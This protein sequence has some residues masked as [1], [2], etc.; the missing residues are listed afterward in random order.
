MIT[1]VTSAMRGPMLLI[2]SGFQVR[3]ALEMVPTLA[4]VLDND[5]PQDIVGHTNGDVTE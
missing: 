5:I 1:F 3:V 2:V 4:D